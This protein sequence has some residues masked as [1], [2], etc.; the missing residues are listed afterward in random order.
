VDLLHGLLDSVADLRQ[1]DL[2]DDVET[3]IGH[4]F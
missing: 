1:V 2:G 4:R 3:V